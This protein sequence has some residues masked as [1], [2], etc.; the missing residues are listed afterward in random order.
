MNKFD[1]KSD[2]YQSSK[3]VN[4]VEKA[5]HRS[6]LKALGLSNSDMRRPF[7]A[8][9]NSYNEIVPG[10]VELKRVVEAVKKGILLAGGIPFEI[11]AIAVCDGIAMNH[12]GMKYSLASRELIADSIE[13]MVKAH[14]FDG[15][16]F[17]PNCDKTVPGMLMAAARINRPSIFVSGGPML[18]GKFSGDVETLEQ[19]RKGSVNTDI[20]LTTAFEAVGAYQNEK[21]GLEVF[22]EIENNACPTCGSCSGMFT[23]NS[24]NCITECLGMALPGNGTI[25]AVYQDRVR[26]AKETGERIVALVEAN[27]KPQDIMTEAALKNALTVDMALGCSTNTILHLTAISNELNLPVTLDDFDKI[28]LSTP[29]LCK[30]SPAGPWHI[31]DL[32]ADGG[33]NAVMKELSKLNLLDLTVKTVTESETMG[34]Q[35]AAHNRKGK[36]II[37]SY[38]AP[39]SATGGLKVLKGSL[40]PNG[41]VVKQSAV[42][43]SMLSREGKARVFESEEEATEAILTKQIREGDVVI[44]R[45]EGPKGGPGMRE[46]LTP[47]SALSGMGLDDSVALI[48]DGRFSGGTRG[49]A[50]GHVSPEA[51]EGGPIGLVEE[52]DLIE[53]NIPKGI[54]NLKV[55][56]EVLKERIKH[57]KL[58]EKPVTGYL[59]RYR[60]AVESADKGAISRINK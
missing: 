19:I 59:D 47:T 34:V 7:V 45:Y 5:P 22:E 37:A 16:V 35:I 3:I 32:H 4:G 15:I 60:Y 24:M 26:L 48:T 39:Y 14:A 52:G 43:A 29:N 31:S 38:E 40:A 51:F 42:A 28:C 25:P 9:V 10:H 12:E 41:A 23:A 50:I 55:S 17:I 11:P 21:I 36:G 2:K 13:I 54:L 46:M 58:K 53:I 27:L 57:L 1:Y 56:E 33:I 44:I 20:D 6:L 30:L 49:A 8:V 18:A